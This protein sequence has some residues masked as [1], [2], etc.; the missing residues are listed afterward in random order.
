MDNGTPP[1]NAFTTLLARA[2]EPDGV[3][4]TALRYHD[5]S[6]SYRDL[7]ER[8]ARAGAGLARLGVQPENRVLFLMKDSPAMV[9]AWLGTLHI[10]AVAVAYNIRASAAEIR[11]AVTDSR[12]RALVATCRWF[13]RHSTVSSTCRPWSAMPG[14]STWC[15]SDGWKPAT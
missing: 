7:A 3:D 1:G 2:A 6:V 15:R 10:G 8:A 13:A 9:A 11:H 5:T 4:A 14:T 12:C